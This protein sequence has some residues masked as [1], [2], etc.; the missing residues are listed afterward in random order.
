MGFGLVFIALIIFLQVGA[1]IGF[2]ITWIIFGIGVGLLSPAY[3]SLISKVVPQKMLGLFTGMF[4]SSLGL[5]SLPAPWIGAKLWEIFN[6][7]FPFWITIGAVFVTLIPVWFKFKV[8][9]KPDPI[10]TSEVEVIPDTAV[11]P[12]S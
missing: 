8:P 9:D 5:I 7:K 11:E 3:S 12:T 2:A 1:F 10:G 4:R 6:P